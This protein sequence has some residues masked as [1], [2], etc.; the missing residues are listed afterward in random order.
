MQNLQFFNVLRCIP[1][2]SPAFEE[3]IRDH[4][5]VWRGFGRRV[6]KVD[7]WRPLHARGK[8]PR[9]LWTRRARW[10]SPEGLTCF[11]I[12]FPQNRK[13]W[14]QNQTFVSLFNLA[15]ACWRQTGGKVPVAVTSRRLHRKRGFIRFGPSKKLSEEEGGEGRVRGS[16]LSVRTRLISFGADG[17]ITYISNI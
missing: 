8:R 4:R 7:R 3:S 2:F 15:S 11:K 9:C 5:E 13:Y 17:S 1:S 6:W 16:T 14:R 10:Q 12:G